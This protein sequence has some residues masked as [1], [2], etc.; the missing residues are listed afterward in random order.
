MCHAACAV[1][2]GTSYARQAEKATLEVC[3]FTAVIGILEIDLYH[4]QR[5]LG[6]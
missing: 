4:C 2:V 6:V 1:E 3:V 5:G